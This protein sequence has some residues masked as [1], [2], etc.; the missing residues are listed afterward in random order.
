MKEK[1]MYASPHVEAVELTP[2]GTLLA[3]SETETQ[4]SGIN[5]LSPDYGGLTW[6]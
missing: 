6:D 5:P 2:G 3:G 4:N 1:Q